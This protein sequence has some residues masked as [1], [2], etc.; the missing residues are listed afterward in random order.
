MTETLEASRNQLEWLW[1]GLPPAERV[2][3]SALAEASLEAISQEQLEHVLHDS[4]VRVMIRELQNAPE[5]LEEWDLIERVDDHHR[6]RVELL[7]RWIFDNKPLRR[8]QEEL[9]RIEPAAENLYQAASAIYRGGQLEQAIAPLQQAIS[10]NPNHIGANQLLADILI[11]Q[12]QPG[13]AI[14]LLKLLSEYQPV[15]ARPRLIQALI[16]QAQSIDDEDEQLNY[17]EQVLELDGNHAEAKAWQTQ[18]WTKR[19]DLASQIGRLDIA[20]EAYTKAGLT[21]RVT[22]M[23]IDIRRLEFKTKLDKVADLENRGRYEAALLEAHALAA[24]F[25]E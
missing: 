22:Q 11:T 16:A 10:L 13:E 17:Y 20:L 9:D 12:D 5:L 23:M 19:G 6:F 14:Q 1:D 8:V 3:A 18:I 25:P 24:N 2:V 7:R 15:A 4:G 21:D